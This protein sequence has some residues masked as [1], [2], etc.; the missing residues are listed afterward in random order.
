[1]AQI[2]LQVAGADFDLLVN[3]STVSGFVFELNLQSPV[4]ALKRPAKTGAAI[5]HHLK[6]TQ[7]AEATSCKYCQFCSHLVDI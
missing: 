5:N 7:V 4:T 1:M 6:G 3:A 2:L